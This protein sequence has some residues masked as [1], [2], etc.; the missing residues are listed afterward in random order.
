MQFQQEN[1]FFNIFPQ[2]Y[3]PSLCES[4][5]GVDGG[6][7]I[8]TTRYNKKY[9]SITSILSATMS[10]EKRSILESWKERVGEEEAENIKVEAARRGSAV[11]ELVEKYILDENF[12]ETLEKAT[13][14]IKRLFNQLKPVLDKNVNNIRMIEKSLF[15]DRL[16]VAGRTDLIAEYDKKLSICDIKTSTKIKT[17]DEIQDYMLQECFY[18]YC[19]AE[20][21]GEKIQSIVTL[22]A[23]ENSLKPII[24]IDTPFKH[25]DNLKK[26]IDQYYEENQI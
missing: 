12:Y 19:Y 15:S 2:H 25:L 26:R 3:T 17:I 10:V 7:R 20:Q 23:T 22:I 1:K 21:F 6:P 4:I 13:P 14:K 16:M 24:F 11:H 8:Y 5:D 18:S 9:P